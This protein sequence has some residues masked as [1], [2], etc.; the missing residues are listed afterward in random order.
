MKLAPITLFVYNRLSHTERTAEALKA[1]Q[2]ANESELIIFSDGS[3]NEQDIEK[4][5]RVRA[6]IKR[7][8][9]F[10]RVE[11]IER[12]ENYGL[13][14]SI[15]SGVTEVVNRYG[16]IIVMEDDLISSPYFLK[17]MNEGLDF[18]ENQEKVISIHG[19]TL[20]IRA[21]M[22][23]TY[24]LRRADCWGWA[25]WKRGWGLFESDGEKL[26]K[27]IQRNKLEKYFDINGSYP[28]IDIL[29]DQIKG[30]NDS[31]A[32]RWLATAFINNKLTLYPGKSLIQNIGHDNTGTHCMEVDFYDVELAEEPI[33]IKTIPIE[34]NTVVL[35]GIA[36][37]YRSIG[38]SWAKKTL[39]KLYKYLIGARFD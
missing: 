12:Q 4:V 5:L 36:K 29:K 34:E 15:I 8:K 6:Y 23:E 26:L 20:P 9:G 25:T 10:K 32:V 35:E 24:F 14:N 19:Y 31:W 37:F 21:Q 13:A 3:K 16:S 17:F 33:N 11:I 28:F 39:K 27:E 1:N 18:Y 38:P 30:K 22:P 2:Y 7:I